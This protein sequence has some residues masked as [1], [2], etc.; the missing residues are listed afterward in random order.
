MVLWCYP[1]L[2]AITLLTPFLFIYLARSLQS[3]APA[4]GGVAAAAPRAGEHHRVPERLAT[5]RCGQEQARGDRQAAALPWRLQE[6][7][8]SSSR[9]DDF[10]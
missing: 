10:H 6:R 7:R 8:V 3:W 4:G 5:P 1:S 2:F 9:R